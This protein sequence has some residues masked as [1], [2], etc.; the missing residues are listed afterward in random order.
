MKNIFKALFC[1]HDY[2][3]VGNIAE[4]ERKHLFGAPRSMWK[5]KKCGTKIYSQKAYEEPKNELSKT[6]VPGERDLKK[7]LSELTKQY[8]DNQQ[9]KWEVKN[10]DSLNELVQTLE[11]A[12]IQGKSTYR[13]LVVYNDSDFERFK[14]FLER[15][16]L[17]FTENTISKS[18][19]VNLKQHE[20]TIFWN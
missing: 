19:D 20:I 1:K 2:E 6:I 11:N 16:N 9:I 17:S 7:E 18:V 4:H 13:L 12:A 15:T 3:F 10:H 8:Y 5:C 14:K